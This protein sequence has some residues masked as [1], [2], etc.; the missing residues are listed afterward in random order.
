M[1]DGNLA[2]YLFSFKLKQQQHEK[3]IYCTVKYYFTERM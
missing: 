3:I 2:G 1:Q